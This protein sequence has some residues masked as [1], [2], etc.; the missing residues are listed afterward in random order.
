M[1]KEGLEPSSS[2]LSGALPTELLLRM[3]ALDGIEP[4]FSRSLLSLSWPLDDKAVIPTEGIAPPTPDGPL[5]GTPG[6]SLEIGAQKT[7]GRT[8]ASWGESVTWSASSARP[9]ML[10]HTPTVGTAPNPVKSF[11]AVP[12]RASQIESPG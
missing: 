3:E 9:S 7:P 12:E 11:R 10:V 2:G 6:A 1:Q 8:F 4:S 5:G